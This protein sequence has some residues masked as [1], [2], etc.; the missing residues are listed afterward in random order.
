MAP[1]L[2]EWAKHNRTWSSFSDP[3]PLKT[4]L[5]GAYEKI[6][7]GNPGGATNE[8][9]PGKGEDVVELAATRLR[10]PKSNC[11]FIMRGPE[12]PMLSLRD[13]LIAPKLD[14]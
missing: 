13:R 8:A 7:V 5:R 3:D 9:S 14:S 6:E 2:A 10:P 1:A 4:M 11:A 12:A